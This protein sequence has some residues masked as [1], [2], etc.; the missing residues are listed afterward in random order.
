[1]SINLWRRLSSSGTIQGMSGHSKW[2][3]IKRQK[4]TKDQARGKIF[5]K[6]AKSIV[7]AVKA[8]G[9]SNPETNY[10]L[11]MA[12]E[13][14]RAAN[15]P[16]DNIERAISRAASEPANIEEITYEG[17]GPGGI[18]IIVEVATDNRN[19][20]GQEIKNIFEKQRGSFAPGALAHNFEPKGFLLVE[21]KSPIDEQILA[22]IDL[23]VE[24]V[25]EGEDG[26]EIYTSPQELFDKKNLIEKQGFKVL[27]S[28]LTKKPKTFVLIK[29]PQTSQRV[30]ALLHGLEEHE[31]VENVYTNA[32]LTKTD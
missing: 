11:R 21:K 10:K 6:L 25:E 5:S 8:G 27:E 7:V 4:E 30:E 32:D 18:G 24:G 22:L 13:T 19:R 1:M 12:I 3:T 17:F 14:A 20:T 28:S 29:D 23:G 26:I 16:K 2:S 31:D 15:M 9:S